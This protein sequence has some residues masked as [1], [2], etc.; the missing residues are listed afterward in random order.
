M[1]A[2]ALSSSDSPASNAPQRTPR[3]SRTLAPRPATPHPHQETT[4]ACAAGRIAPHT[5]ST[6]RT[7]SVEPAAR[8]SH[9]RSRRPPAPADASHPFAG[10]SPTGPPPVA[11][12]VTGSSPITDAR[13]RH[14]RAARFTPDN[15]ARPYPGFTS[16]TYHPRMAT[17]QSPGRE[18]GASQAEVRNRRGRPRT[19]DATIVV[20]ATQRLL[21]Q[22]LA[23]SIHALPGAGQVTITSDRLELLELCA[24]LQPHLL[25]VT[26][27]PHDAQAISVIT[28]ATERCPHTA[29]ALLAHDASV[30]LL[31][32]AHHAGT[33]L[34]L[35]L[36]ADADHLTAGLASLL[37]PP[38]RVPLAVWLQ[39]S[40]HHA[41]PTLLPDTRSV[42]LAAQQQRLLHLIARG[43]TN[44]RIG[45]ELGLS[46]K[47]VRNHVS[48]ILAKL[49]ARTRTEA[50]FIALSTNLI[51]LPPE[52]PPARHPRHATPDAARTDRRTPN[53][54][55]PE[56]TPRPHDETS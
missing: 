24:T 42:P 36:A 22:A 40:A 2:H 31:H 54:S 10:A 9:G 15:Q 35:P 29:T 47:T 19:N 43:L 56:G 1:G 51:A 33:S 52:R 46:E 32:D 48:R 27:A 5:M 20:H 11:S 3:L 4:P 23:A 26:T 38:H 50:V 14:D 45:A 49:G 53:P 8:H 16:S 41:T 25:V 34:V 21:G 44:A 30:P 12:P 39:H 55:P 17:R 7:T 37:R 13:P 18:P 28:A 6:N